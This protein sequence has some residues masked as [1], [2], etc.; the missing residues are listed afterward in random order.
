MSDAERSQVIVH[1]FQENTLCTECPRLPTK[2]RT[3]GSNA[4]GEL[5]RY[6]LLCIIITYYRILIL[7]Y[8]LPAGRSIKK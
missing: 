6:P 2:K 1:D 7:H 4:C 5:K 3:N 8:A